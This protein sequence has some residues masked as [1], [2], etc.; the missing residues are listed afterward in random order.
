LVVERTFTVPTTGVGRKDYS[1][2]T[3]FS[4]QPYIR[5]HQM[6]ILYYLSMTLP[7]LPY[8]NAW[9]TI[10]PFRQEKG[11]LGFE[12]SVYPYFFYNLTLSTNRNTLL[13]AGL[14]RWDSYARL[15]AGLPPD[16]TV[17]EKFDYGTVSINFIKGVRLKK[18]SAYGF[19]V[20]ELL[21]P[22]FTFYTVTSAI[23]ELVPS[24]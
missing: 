21:G 3:E 19:M 8:G 15:T 24:D 6:P 10:F 5:S 1:L 22:V 11:G 17:C 13:Y 18:G 2:Q 12:V 14:G 7:S 23:L 9:V 4:V 16:E 20:N